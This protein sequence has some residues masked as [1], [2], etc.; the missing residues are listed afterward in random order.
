ML[1]N[2]T[3]NPLINMP[4]IAT[5]ESQKL[6]GMIS[7]NS[8]IRFF[9][10][11]MLDSFRVCPRKFYFSHI[12]HFQTAGMRAPLTFGSSIHS[13]LDFI[14]SEFNN[15]NRDQL[16]EGAMVNFMKVWM[17]DGLDKVDEFDLYPRTP[18]RAISILEEYIERYAHFLGSIELIAVE[19]PFIVPLFLEDETVGYVGKLDKIFSDR[20]G[21]QFCDHK[22]SSTFGPSW[23]N[24]FSPN[25]QMDGYLHAGH[26]SYGD[27]FHGILIDGLL[28]NKTKIDLLRIPIQRQAAQ[29]DAWSWEVSD[30]IDLI[31]LNEERLVEYRN[32]PERLNYLPAFPKCTTSCTQ[33]FGTCP[34][35]ELCRFWDNPDHHVIPDNFVERKWEPFNI[36]EQP[37]GSI[38]VIDRE[39]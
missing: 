22:T 37:D 32:S 15:M 38:K 19:S 20:Y 23:T 35:H 2:E 18:G 31:E 27:S 3:V 12:R 36:L 16:L 10:N 4:K 29:V 24:S 13:A 25:G 33:Y 30:L 39:D 17:K 1:S 21:V 9:D 26:T 8:Q 14:W 7:N 5:R 28:V 6:C 11:S 34:Y